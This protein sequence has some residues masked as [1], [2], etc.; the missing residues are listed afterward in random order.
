VV[1]ETR[2][3]AHG[4]QYRA[5]ASCAS[6]EGRSEA[7]RRWVNSSIDYVVGFIT[8]SGELFAIRLPLT[9]AARL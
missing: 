3:P 5:A 4:R 1:F 9:N 8:Y 6:E 7:A 2:I